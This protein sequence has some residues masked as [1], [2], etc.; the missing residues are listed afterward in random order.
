LLKKKG[1]QK[2]EGKEKRDHR[3]RPE[4]GEGESWK[5][6]GKKRVFFYFNLI[7]KK[8][9]QV[10]RKKKPARKSREKKRGGES[11]PKGG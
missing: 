9:L 2:R 6:V 7:G 11:V 5:M 4:L 10:Q 3:I 1:T 8:R